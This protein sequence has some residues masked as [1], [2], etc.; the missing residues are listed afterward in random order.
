M[1]RVLRGWGRAALGD[2]TDGIAELRDG[3]AQSSATGAHMDEAYYLGLL[4][5]ACLRDGDADG[6]RAALDEA[7]AVLPRDGRF[8]HEA[9]LQRL[10]GEV[11]LR[12]GDP[13]AAERAMRRARD[14]ARAQGARMPELRAS[15]GLGAVLR[16][17]G[18]PNEA[19][20]AVAE[21]L[22]GL[23]E[24]FDSPDVR[25]AA[26]FLAA[27]GSQPGPGAAPPVRYARSGDLSIA[28]EVTGR[29]PRDLVL[30]P[31]FISHLEQDRNEPRH[32][33]FLDRLAGLGRLIRFDKRGTGLSDRPPG[34]PD[35]EARMDDV[36]AVMDAA[37]S[38]RAVL[39]GYS[40]GCPMSVL[41][42][43]T[44][45]ERVQPASS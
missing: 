35:L 2:T 28:Y 25:A 10:R 8:F 16:A 31:G 36:R 23:T 45:P 27:D 40:E 43:A 3:I 30:V 18:R 33:R 12:D 22:G 39:V 42:A 11:A 21:A 24:G 1:G 5:D 14:V 44:Y 41:F 26:A 19:R 4:A 38:R 20:A 13:E 15:L 32:A 17:T 6:A 29:G 37:G 7:R 9:E 34:V